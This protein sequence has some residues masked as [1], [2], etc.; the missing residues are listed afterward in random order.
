[1]T[2]EKTSEVVKSFRETFHNISKIEVPTFALINGF[3]LGGGLELALNCDFRLAT[4]ESVVGL[5]ETTLAIIPGLDKQSDWYSEASAT[6][7]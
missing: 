2:E 7:W 5:P 3:A 1:M 4:K 6:D